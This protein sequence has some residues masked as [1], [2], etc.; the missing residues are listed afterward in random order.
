M[1]LDGQ[2]R[3]RPVG[4][5]GVSDLL[6]CVDQLP[7][8]LTTFGRFLPIAHLQRT[9]RNDMSFCCGAGLRAMATTILLRVLL[10]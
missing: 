8:S 6:V 2:R 7:L 5:H 1:R 3:R 10:D 9:H 4:R